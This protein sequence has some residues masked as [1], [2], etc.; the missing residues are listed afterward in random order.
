M[1]LNIIKFFFENL[2]NYEKIKI[3]S[4]LFLSFLNVILNITQIFLIFFLISKVL[5]INE[6]LQNIKVFGDFFNE[7]SITNLIYLSFFLIFT[8]IFV[9]FF[10]IKNSFKQLNSF[11]SK[12]EKIFFKNFINRKYNFYKKKNSYEVVKTIVDNFPRLVMG[13][14]Y[15]L[16]QLFTN[17]LIF[18]TIFI[19]LSFLNLKFTV[20]IS[21][22]FTSL[23]III[24]YFIKKRIIFFQ[25]QESNAVT[26]RANQSLNAFNFF[27]EIKI[28]NLFDRFIFNFDEQ[29]LKF[30]SNRSKTYLYSSFPKYVLEYVVTLLILVFFLFINKLENIIELI[31]VISFYIMATFRLLPC[32]ATTL[33]SVSNIKSNYIYFDLIKNEIQ[34]SIQENES[35]NFNE[36]KFNQEIFK[37]T[38]RDLNYKYST[39][40][41]FNEFNFEILKKD[42][43]FM[44]GETG[45]GKSTLLDIIS[46]LN[47]SY[48]GQVIFNDTII[49]NYLNAKTIRDKI[50]YCSQNPY[51]FEDTLKNNITLFDQNFDEKKFNKVLNICKVNEIIE[52][53][54]I[55]IKDNIAES[56]LNLSGGEK[57]RISL[58]RS[59]YKNF[60]VLI[61]D[62]S[63]NS[64]N[65]QMEREIMENIILYCKEKIIITCSHN[66]SLQEL[67]NK[68]LR[69]KKI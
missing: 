33:G 36:E 24:Y 6:N 40:K 38:I 14:F 30:Y 2:N 17:I 4:T 25:T 60:D 44:S 53:K 5:N 34:N 54:N 11:T 16:I 37:I 66:L 3:F 59:L 64:L 52:K 28:F 9:N 12:L 15:P 61:L 13:I 27:R 69:I 58:A 55:K 62:E 47:I 45:S 57:Q 68:R 18:I 35:I 8:N 22:L 7:L 41:I 65:E 39:N 46:G 48:D 31:P 51:L 21:L 19:S 26:K 10:Y 42:K 67:F 20:I 49:L 56:G 50:S 29:S 43:I 1:I 23:V 32:F 63:T